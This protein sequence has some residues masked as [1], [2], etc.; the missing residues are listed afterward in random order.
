MILLALPALLLA[1]ASL[2]AFF[3]RWVWWLDLLANFRAQYA[4][5]LVPLGVVLVAARWRKVGWAVLVA[6]LLNLA[7][8]TPLYWQSPPS[9]VVTGERVRILSFNVKASNDRFDEVLGY[10]RGLDPDVVFLHEA[11]RPWEEAMAA[12]GLD[13]QVVPGRSAEH[14]FG[15]LV[16]APPQARVRS[17][18]FTERSPRAV[19]VLMEG[20][21]GT[22]IAILGIHP[23]SPVT[24]R[25]AALRDAQL[26]WAAQWAAGRAEATVVVGDFNATPWSY[27]FRRLVG[28]TDLT[29]SQR[30]F[31]LDASFPADNSVLI[32]VPIDHLLHNDG[33]VVI[34]RRL[35][36]PLGSDHFPLVVDLAVVAG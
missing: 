6:G 29:N 34:D 26:G 10:I 30:G 12:A 23:L 4:L 15:T 5:A 35:G 16:L 9:A 21:A 17:F 22:P 36:P 3:G 11:S 19:E 27:P 14:I 1:V 8:V 13:Y 25:D 20:S 7:L 18:G 24:E 32:R 2:A 28:E 33:L 31:G